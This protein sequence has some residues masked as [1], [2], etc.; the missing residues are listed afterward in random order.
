MDEVDDRD[1][2]PVRADAPSLDAASGKCRATGVIDSSPARVRVNGVGPVTSRR[3]SGA[4][5][6]VRTRADLAVLFTGTPCGPFEACLVASNPIRDSGVTVWP[7]V[8]STIAP[9]PE[10]TTTNRPRRSIAGIAGGANRS[11]VAV[12]QRV[13]APREP[14]SVRRPRR[15]SPGGR[16]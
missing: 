9:I 15:A 14:R 4:L 12:R 11:G 10:P 1:A 3:Q 6:R 8:V 5:A 2:P 16:T 7:T 13:L